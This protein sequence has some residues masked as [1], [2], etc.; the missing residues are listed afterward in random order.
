MS[1]VTVMEFISLIMLVVGLGMISF[2]FRNAHTTAPVRWQHKKA[3][4]R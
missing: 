4:D 3:T 2:D 1:S